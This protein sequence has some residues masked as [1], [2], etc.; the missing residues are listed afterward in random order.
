MNETEKSTLEGY[1]SLGFYPPQVNLR[2]RD[3]RGSEYGYFCVTDSACGIEVQKVDKHGIHQWRAFFN[4]WKDF[5]A[6][7]RDCT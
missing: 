7:A 2:K 4:C 6:W 1:A 3:P 5:A